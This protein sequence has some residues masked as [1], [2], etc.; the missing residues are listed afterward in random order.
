MNVV[1]ISTDLILTFHH[2][3]DKMLCIKSYINLFVGVKTM[4]PQN[5]IHAYGWE[6]K[7]KGHKM[8]HSEMC[9]FHKWQLSSPPIMSLPK[10]RKLRKLPFLWLIF[11][12]NYINPSHIFIA[13]GKAFHYL[14]LNLEL[15]KVFSFSDSQNLLK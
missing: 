2:P 14:M 3:C 1:N 7:I 4:I 15:Q 13:Y 11:S 10:Q 8:C 9:V 12:T 6:T 5:F